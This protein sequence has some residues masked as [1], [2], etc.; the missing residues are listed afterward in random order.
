MHKLATP[1]VIYAVFLTF[2][3]IFILTSSVL[4]MAYFA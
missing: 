1:C 2:C 3:L 4:N